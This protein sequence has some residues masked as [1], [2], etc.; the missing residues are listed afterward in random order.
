MIQAQSI[1]T[2]TLPRALATTWLAVIA[3]T[4][5]TENPSLASLR[6]LKPTP[7]S[8]WKKTLTTYLCAKGE[9]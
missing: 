9:S 2:P 6:R 1:L 5:N 4:P 8:A 7:P 3:L